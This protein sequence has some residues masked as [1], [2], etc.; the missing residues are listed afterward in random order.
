MLKFE[1]WNNISV[2]LQVRH[3]LDVEAIVTIED[4]EELDEEEDDLSKSCMRLI[5][6]GLYIFHR[7]AL[8]Q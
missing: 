4:E 8:G 2:D 3:F 1:F 5:H 6:S 7:Q